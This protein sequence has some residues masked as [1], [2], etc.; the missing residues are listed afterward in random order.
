MGVGVKARAGCLLRSAPPRLPTLALLTRVAKPA[1]PVPVPG[2][3]GRAQ[4]SQGMGK[5]ADTKSQ[6]GGGHREVPTWLSAQASGH[7]LGTG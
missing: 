6:G 4:S 3:S 5:V 2:P 1:K 7:C